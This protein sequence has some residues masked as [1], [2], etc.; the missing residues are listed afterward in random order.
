MRSFRMHTRMHVASRH[1]TSFHHPHTF[2]T[3]PDALWI[4]QRR[5]AIR[6]CETRTACECRTAPDGPDGPH[7]R[8]EPQRRSSTPQG[9]DATTCL[10]PDRFE[11]MCAALREWKARYYTTVVPRTV[12]EVVELAEWCSIVRRLHRKRALPEW[13]VARLEA[14]GM[15]WKVDVVTAKWHANFHAVRAFKAARGGDACDVCTALPAGYSNDDR[16]DWVEA[17]RWLERQR[18]LYRQQKLTN[19]RVRMLKEILGE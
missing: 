6:R 7:G 12:S 9:V 10:E 5:T 13:A 15:M 18:E 17:S 14:L 3:V 8:A 16:P 4:P 1:P 11:V 19:A 2:S